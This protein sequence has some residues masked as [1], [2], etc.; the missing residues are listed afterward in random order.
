M[1]RGHPRLRLSLVG[2]GGVRPDEFLDM[3]CAACPLPGPP[4]PLSP[5]HQLPSSWSLSC[6]TSVS[7]LTGALSSLVSLFRYPWYFSRPVP[8]SPAPCHLAPPCPPPLWPCTVLSPGGKRSGCPPLRQTHCCGPLP[9]AMPPVQAAS[10]LPCSTETTVA[11]WV[12][13]VSCWSRS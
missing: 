4:S 12:G 8:F 7:D 11:E 1:G 10:H 6:K 9:G 5:L 13:M 3:G 2:P